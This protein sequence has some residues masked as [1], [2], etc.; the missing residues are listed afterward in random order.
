M[1]TKR[2]SVTNRQVTKAT[3]RKSSKKEKGLVVQPNPQTSSA[4]FSLP[5]NKK[6]PVIVLSV[7][8]L[9]GLLFLISK[10]LVFAWVDKIPVTRVELYKRLDARY[11]KDIKDQ[12]ITEQLILNEARNRGVSVSNDEINAEYKKI[13]D[14]VGAEMLTSL[15]SQQNVNENTFRDQLKFQIL[16][17][18]MFSQNVSVSD[19]E[20]NKVIEQQASGS[21]NPAPV[22]DK[23]KQEI[24]DQLLQQKI[25]QNFKTWLQ[26]ALQSS[27]VIRL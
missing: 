7:L 22:D 6:L 9:A 8:V 2:K 14:Q 15:L 25:S 27:R 1:A 5:R 23:Q 17:R 19:D 18:K 11:G 16:V 24:K 3:I 4:K 10:W 12:I 21:A 20:V 13:Q 26:G